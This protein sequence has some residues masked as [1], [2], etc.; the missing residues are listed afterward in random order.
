[1]AEYDPN[2]GTVDEVLKKLEKASPDEQKRI[3][4]A[5]RT[6]KARTTILEAYGVDP[7]ERVDATG[8]V[9]Y[10]WEVAS[11]EQVTP[12]KVEESKE[13]AKARQAQAEFDDQAAA[14]AAANA[15]GSEQGAV[16]APGTGVAAAGVATAPSATT[17]AT[18]TTG[19][20]GR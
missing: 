12:V 16:T 17:T 5:E 3:L 9:L 7:N 14:A 10:P 18:G 1:M 19:T 13:A 6:G 4:A 20:T 15:G 11:E 2:D 8:R